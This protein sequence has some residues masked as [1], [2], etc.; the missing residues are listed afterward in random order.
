MGKK[1]KK[2][3]SPF[4]SQHCVLCGKV[5][6]KGL[7]EYVTG[8]TGRVVCKACL[9]ISDRV[10]IGQSQQLKHPEKKPVK[11]PLTPQQIIQELDKTII[12]QERAKRAIALAFWKQQLRADGD[13]S[14]PRTNIL[15]YGPTGCGKTAL[16]QQASKI[17]GLPFISFDATTLSETG[18]R[19]KDAVDIIK[20]YAHRFSDHPNL[21]SGVVFIDETD[22][23]AARGSDTRTEY[24]KG[25]Q[26]SLLKLVEGAEV[27]CD[28]KTLFTDRLLFIFG[29]AFTGIR[30]NNAS[31]K[32]VG[33]IGFTKQPRQEELVRH[34]SVSDFV[35][36]GMEPELMGRVG[37]CVPLEQLTAE[38]LKRILLESELSLFRQ[39]QKF[40]DGRGIRLDLS[41]KQVDKLVQGALARGTGARGLNSLVEETLE[42]LLFRLAEGR[43]EGKVYLDEQPIL[44][45]G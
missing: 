16:T 37:Q 20:E 36:F 40:F 34:I 1:K 25:T 44:Y 6:I 9:G 35:R 26:H 31:V 43:L 12:G 22:K 39:Y 23:L 7:H 42:P 24:N 2:Q 27:D 3:R 45:A 21:Q 38:D 8:A 30:N 33:P 19:G 18:Y 29:G 17:V 13:E 32:Q 28:D 11:S 5:V 10:M 15:L 4:E 41:D 14:V